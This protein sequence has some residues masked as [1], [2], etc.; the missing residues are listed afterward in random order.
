MKKIIIIC[1]VSLCVSLVPL[2]SCGTV[3]WINLVKL[4]DIT[5]DRYYGNVSINGFS[6]NDLTIYDSVKYKVSDNILYSHHKFGNNEATYL[7]KGTILY[8][9]KD[10][11]P[12]FLLIV[13][14][15]P[16]NKFIPPFYIY[17]A[18]TNPHA[19]TGG[20]LLD[21][22]GKIAYIGINSKT[23]GVTRLATINDGNTVAGLVEMIVNA[24]VD[25]NTN[26]SGSELYFLDFF[27]K[28]GLEIN[29]GYMLDTNVLAGGIVL[30]DNFKQLIKASLPATIIT[31]PTEAR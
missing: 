16:A 5:Y 1:L 12:S 25:Q 26:K 17:L 8:S 2:S 31:T 14:N 28:D 3:D 7:E 30:P 19:K 27:F 4:N 10:Y 6:D 13:K 18:R 20:D 9:L 22:E 23:D 29:R 24:P 15:D 21:I 11:S